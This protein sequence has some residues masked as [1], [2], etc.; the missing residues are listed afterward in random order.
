MAP[1]DIVIDV[2]KQKKEEY[3]RLKE[4]PES[5]LTFVAGEIYAIS[6]AIRTF[7]GLKKLFI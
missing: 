1:I 6:D 3:K 4:D 7:E 2:L 5:D